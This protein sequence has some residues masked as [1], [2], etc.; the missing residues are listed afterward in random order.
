MELVSLVDDLGF[1][2]REVIRLQANAFAVAAMPSAGRAA[3]LDELDALAR[4]IPPGR[5]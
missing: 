2:P 1:G 4:E 5:A 3:V